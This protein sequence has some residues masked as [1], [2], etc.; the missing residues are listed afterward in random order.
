M[1]HSGPVIGQEAIR[2]TPTPSDAISRPELPRSLKRFPPFAGQNMRFTVMTDA[3]KLIDGSVFELQ[4]IK[5]M[6]D[7][8]ERAKVRIARRTRPH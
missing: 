6:G 8:L 7:T 3:R 2:K 1:A 5:L 4:T